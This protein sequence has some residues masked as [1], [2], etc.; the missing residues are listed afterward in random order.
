MSDVEQQTAPRQLRRP[1]QC[2]QRAWGT[3]ENAYRL[4]QPVMRLCFILITVMALLHLLKSA[5]IPMQGFSPY[6]P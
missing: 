3:C 2:S 4:T 1:G 6:L 5:L